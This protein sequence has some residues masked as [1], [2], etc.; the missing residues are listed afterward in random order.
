MLPTRR[1][2]KRIPKA[3]DIVLMMRALSACIPMHAR[4]NHGLRESLKG[5]VN[6]RFQCI[7]YDV[8]WTVDVYHGDF[9]VV[10]ARNFNQPCPSVSSAIKHL[11]RMLGLK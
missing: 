5:V 1:Q 8:D 6:Y 9:F 3:K 4:P 11:L 2:K 10:G 7:T